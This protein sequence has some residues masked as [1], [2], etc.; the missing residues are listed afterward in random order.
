MW[1]L[2]VCIA[3]HKLL[4]DIE[5]SDYACG[6]MLNLLV[7]RIKQKLTFEWLSNYVSNSQLYI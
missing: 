2:K 7:V 3:K 6:S 1:T 4:I 5:I